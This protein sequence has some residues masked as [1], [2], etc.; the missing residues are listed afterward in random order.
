MMVST[1]TRVVVAAG[2]D[3]ITQGD[4]DATHF[5]VLE[6]GTAM[7]RVRPRDD[8][9]RGLHSSTCQLNQSRF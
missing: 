4:E 2:Q 1:M 9:G 6:S 3:I 5:Y 7:I 8:S